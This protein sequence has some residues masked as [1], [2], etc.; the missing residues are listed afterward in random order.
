LCSAR[1]VDS[2][3]SAWVWDFTCQIS[4]NLVIFLSFFIIFGH[5]SIILYHFFWCFWLPLRV[6]AR[7]KPHYQYQKRR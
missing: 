3:K 4:L 5:F 2:I 1:F 6:C 7:P